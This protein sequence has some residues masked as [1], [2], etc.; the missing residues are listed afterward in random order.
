MTT[1]LLWFRQDLRLIDNPAL[2]AAVERGAII[3]V[4]ILD[5]THPPRAIGGA[6]RWWLHHSLSNLNNSLNKKLLLL[7]GDPQ[8]II[9]ELAE[10]NNCSTVMWNRC[11]QPWQIKRDQTLKQ[12]L[13]ENGIDVESF[14][15]SLLWEP[16]QVVKKDQTPY[17]VFT[18]YYR[19]GCLQKPSPRFPVPAP[20]KIRFAKSKTKSLSLNDLE[21]MPTI[22]W[23]QQINEHWLPGEEGAAQRL[24]EFLNNGLANYDTDRNIPS[25][26]GTSKLSPHMHYGEI[27]PNQIWYAALHKGDNNWEDKDLD[28]FLSELGWREF[29]YYLLFHFPTLNKENFNS[30]FDGFPWQQNADDLK[31]WQRGQTGIPIVDAGMRQL[32]Q[33]G[34]MHNRVRMVVASFLVKNLLLHWHEGESWFWDTLLDADLASNSSGWQWVAG[35]GADAA[36][37]FRIFNPVTQGERFDPQGDYVKEYCPELAG[38]PKKYIHQPWLAPEKILK[39][40]GIELGVDYPKP[41]V[42]LKAS[43]ERA[44]QAY[45]QIK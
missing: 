28:C 30:K 15:G 39:E 44:L 32:W 6:S 34:F 11:Y 1:T 14:N 9:P 35:S 41:L 26:S 18:P 42:D 21:L 43:R 2:T 29:S 31:A 40:A 45:Q 12:K 24:Q 10:Q 20:K 19:R 16:W 3:P 22:N 36:P 23:H 33:I 38:L 8:T 27:S 4:Y 13:K 7:Q 25:K 5:D 37:Y 17:R